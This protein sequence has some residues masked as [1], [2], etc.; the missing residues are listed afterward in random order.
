MGLASQ[1]LMISIFFMTFIQKELWR[2]KL[3]TKWREEENSLHALLIECLPFYVFNIY[4]TTCTTCKRGKRPVRPLRSSSSYAEFYS[5]VAK[6][7]FSDAASS[8]SV[9]ANDL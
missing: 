3:P 6:W 9:K 1:P 5:V 7:P 8:S 2:P 4:P